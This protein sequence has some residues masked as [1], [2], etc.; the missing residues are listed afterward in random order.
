MR[1]LPALATAFLLPNAASAAPQ[2]VTDL[3]VV[4]GLVASVIGEDAEPVMLM[5]AG[6]DP[7]AF[8]LRPVRHGPWTTP[9]S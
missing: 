8:Q 5:D 4:Q 6:A 3:T 7:H 1:L 2:V 9:T